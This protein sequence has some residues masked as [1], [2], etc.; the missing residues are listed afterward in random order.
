MAWRGVHEMCHAE[1]MGWGEWGAWRGAQQQH[2][3]CNKHSIDAHKLFREF[4][5]RWPDG[6]REALLPTLPGPRTRLHPSLVETRRYLPPL[7]LLHLVHKLSNPLPSP[8]IDT[9]HTHR[10]GSRSTQNSTLPIPLR[11]LLQPPLL[12]LPRRL[13][14]QPLTSLVVRRRQR[15]P[16]RRRHALP[17]PPWRP[18]SPFRRLQGHVPLPAAG[19][20][21]AD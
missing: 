9:P 13:P 3:T 14:I 10:Y 17:R 18:L 4:E 8:L 15:R 21:R 2:T 16:H 1:C 12:F 5:S 11:R 19:G 7:S 20:V 6:S